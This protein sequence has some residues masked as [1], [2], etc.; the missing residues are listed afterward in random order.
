MEGILRIDSTDAKTRV[1]AGEAM[2]LDVVAPAAWARLPIA[3]RGAVRIPPDEIPDRWRELPRD[4][5]I[6]AYCT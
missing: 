3:I 2:I 5:A 6:I 4:R 1:D